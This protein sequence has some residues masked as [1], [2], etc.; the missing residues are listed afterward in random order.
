MCP[1][2]FRSTPPI[3]ALVTLLGV[4]LLAVSADAQTS[5]LHNN[6]KKFSAPAAEPVL[7]LVGERDPWKIRG[8]KASLRH[9]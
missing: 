7:T 5:G 2:L 8:P 1:P 3:T 4:C 9:S 6:T